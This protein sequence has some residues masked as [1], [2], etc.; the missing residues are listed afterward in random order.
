[1][2]K[3]I[4]SRRP[5]DCVRSVL[6]CMLA[7]AAG[8]P[9][10][11]A[12][13]PAP[14]WLVAKADTVF[15]YLRRAPGAGGFVV[16]RSPAPPAP[17]PTSAPV[18]LTQT[19]VLRVREPAVAAGQLGPDLQMVLRATRAADEIEMLRRLNNDRFAADMLTGLSRN[20]ATVL[21]RLYVDAGVT[22]GAEYEYRVVLTDRA[23]RESDTAFTT[24]IRVVD[25]TPASPTALRARVGDGEAR[26]TWSYPPYRGDARDLVLGFH[27]YRAE[28]TA[29][30]W[31]RVTVTPVVRN[32]ASPLEFIDTEVRN[33]STFRY[34]VTAVDIV[35]RESGP[36]TTA[37]TVVQDRTPPGMP[38]DVIVQEGE[39]VISLSW[40]LAPEP[41]VTG[42]NVERSTGLGD[43][44]QRLN[45]TLIPA[46]RP[47][48]VDTVPGARRFFY[49]V[50]IVDAAGN[51]SDA[52]NPLSAVAKDKIAPT[53]PTNVTATANGR[54]VTVRW[55]ASNARDLRGYYVYRGDAPERLV[56]LVDKPIIGTQFV[57]SGY[58]QK[59]LRPGANYVVE[60]SV[61]DSSFNESKRTRATV[62]IAD[63]DPPSPPTA[64]EA[65]NVLGRH[66]EVDWSASTSLD[67]TAYELSRSLVGSANDSTI[68][69]GRYDAT[70]RA[71]RD[72]T[73]VHTRR[74]IYRLIAVDTAG[75]RS[76]AVLDTVDF[77]D[78]VPPPPPR[79]VAARATATGAGVNV[80]WQRVIA[81][82]LAGYNVY[83]SLVPTGVF[84][85][86]NPAPLRELAFTD[87]GG[88]D[89]YFYMVR[90]VDRSGN[91]S[92]KSPVVAVIK[93]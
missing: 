54:R 67:V 87:R 86:V 12:Q 91:E 45:S 20:A 69:L 81:S 89:G 26:L 8:A 53:A 41:D 77:R 74:Y 60:V 61:V 59:G 48:W 11:S 90:A 10:L 85:R 68:R 22:R 79:V 57:D 4:G 58:Q 24:R 46:Q 75:N 78:F 82:E 28:G 51:V 21:G 40:R 3:T 50:S 27:V 76:P 43:R 35:G 17:R 2:R 84:E 14:V 34:Q 56:R 23:G 92:D 32:D 55:P 13:T 66:V 36:V 39:G 30:T 63:D 93:P 5:R 15:V 33:G 83:R 71:A 7:L 29:G 64:F 44:F 18:K 72:T 88:R 70:K 31:R 1:M 38:Q 65:R 62:S 80:T 47:E 49:R 9:T 19:P 37:P 42:Y 73:P 52:S 6:L 25:I 16:Y